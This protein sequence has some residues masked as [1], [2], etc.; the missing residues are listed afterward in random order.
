[1][2]EF[3]KIQTTI[4]N[5]LKASGLKYSDL[6]QKLDLSLPSVKRILNS[7]DIPLSK[8]IEICR[9]IG[10]DFFELIEQAKEQTAH[11]YQFSLE[12]ENTLSKD[13]QHFLV[14]RLMLVNTEL[15]QIQS[16]LK[17][18]RVDLNRSIK[19]LEKCQL[20][21]LWPNDKIK[22]LAHFPFQW[23][24]SGP[25]EKTYHK[26]IIEKAQKEITKYGVNRSNPTNPVQ[27]VVKELFLT[28]EEQRNYVLDMQMT[29]KKYSMLS[30]MR[31][32]NKS[33]DAKTFSYLHLSGPFLWWEN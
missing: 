3:F 32:K 29:F 26:K 12:Q 15:D 5:S 1:M 9:C 11:V 16:E 18:T 20:I 28:E 24:E 31:M 8:L 25:L 23:I 30:S 17:I 13:F 33:L 22:I 27:C 10:I 7:D 21:E 14:F 2:N 19:A 6:A 4:K